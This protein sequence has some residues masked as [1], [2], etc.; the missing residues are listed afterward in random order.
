[1]DRSEDPEIPWDWDLV[2]GLG[3][4]SSR[5]PW[6]KGQEAPAPFLRRVGLGFRV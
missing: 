1:M 4:G 2:E 5:A 6:A 3:V